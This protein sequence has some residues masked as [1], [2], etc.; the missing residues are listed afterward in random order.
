M[1]E[2][3][4]TECS[5]SSKG[6][7]SREACSSRLYGKSHECEGQTAAA[8]LILWLFISEHMEFFTFVLFLCVR[9]CVWTGRMGSVLWKAG[10]TVSM[11]IRVSWDALLLVTMKVKTGA[12]KLIPQKYMGTGNRGK[13]HFQLC[14][15]KWKMSKQKKV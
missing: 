5:G 4:H 15:G 3:Q 6:K 8:H 1:L 10:R 13:N 12:E 7:N 9:M 2:S 14:M 11:L